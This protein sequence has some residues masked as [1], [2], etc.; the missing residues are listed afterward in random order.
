MAMADAMEAA[1]ADVSRQ[2]S[3]AN[4]PM[5]AMGWIPIVYKDTD[6]LK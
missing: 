3:D 1:K 2:G 4:L 5:P 6:D